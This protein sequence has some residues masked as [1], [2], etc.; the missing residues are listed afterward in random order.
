MEIDYDMQVIDTDDE[1]M[2]DEE[3][4]P[5]EEP[6]EPP[7]KVYNYIDWEILINGGYFSWQKV[8]IFKK[9]LE[10]ITRRGVHAFYIGMIQFLHIFNILNLS[11]IFPRSF[12]TP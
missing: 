10:N 12:T 9:N 7:K 8:K 5:I 4:I 3:N 6:M 2:Q 11:S 1:V